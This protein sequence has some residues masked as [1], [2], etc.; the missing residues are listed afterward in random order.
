MHC[1]IHILYV[2]DITVK[3]MFS[4]V[5]TAF[6]YMQIARLHPKGTLI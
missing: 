2:V 6:P 1:N 3:Y 4:N 5:T